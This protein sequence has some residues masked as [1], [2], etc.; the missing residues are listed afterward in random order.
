MNVDSIVDLSSIHL[1]IVD[2]TVDLSNRHI[3]NVDYTV[4]LS[5]LHLVSVDSNVDIS[6]CHDVSV[7]FSIQNMFAGI[8]CTSLLSCGQCLLLTFFILILN[9]YLLWRAC[10]KDQYLKVCMK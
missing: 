10:G 3:V 6:S 5:S 9:K 4:D 8:I 2:S 1:V 7:D